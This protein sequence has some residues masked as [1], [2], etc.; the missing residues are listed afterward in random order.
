[1]TVGSADK[2]RF[3]TEKF[4]IPESRMFSSRNRWFG[5]EIMKATNGKGIDVIINSLTGDLLEESWMITADGGT[6]VEIGKKDVIDRNWLNTEPFDRNC[7]FRA[8]DF[9]YK[10][11]TDELSAGE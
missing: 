3:L 9:S 7:S 6:M 5:A 4:G 1:M 11:V 10:Q 2:R 8:I